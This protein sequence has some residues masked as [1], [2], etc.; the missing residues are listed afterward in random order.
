MTQNLHLI[1]EGKKKKLLQ[2]VERKRE[3]G[4]TIE[5]VEVDIDVNSIEIPPVPVKNSM[6]QLYTGNKVVPLVF[7]LFLY[8]LS[9]VVIHVV[10]YPIYRFKS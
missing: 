9:G 5:D 2:E 3:T 6:V 7:K 1:T 8:L 4:E 10:V